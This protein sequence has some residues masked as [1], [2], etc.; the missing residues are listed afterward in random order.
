MNF[1]SD[2]I[3]RVRKELTIRK[4]LSIEPDEVTIYGVYINRV[5]MAYNVI[6]GKLNPKLDFNLRFCINSS[7]FSDFKPTR[8]VRHKI[9]ISKKPVGEF[10]SKVCFKDYSLSKIR[11]SDKSEYYEIKASLSTKDYESG[12]LIKTG[13]ILFLTRKEDILRKLNF[14]LDFSQEYYISFVEL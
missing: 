5:G 2:L 1:I 11:S 8:P 12:I 6:T 3:G 7:V 9:I 14:C 13:H 10:Y 4:E